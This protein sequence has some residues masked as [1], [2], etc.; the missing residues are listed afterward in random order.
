MKKLIAVVAMALIFAAGPA[1]AGLVSSATLIDRDE[2]VVGDISAIDMVNAG[3]AA[4]AGVTSSSYAA[5]LGAGNPDVV[6]NDGLHGYRSGAAAL[7]ASSNPVWTLTYSLNGGH[8]ID[9]IVTHSAAEDNRGD[10]DFEV[11]LETVGDPGNFVSLGQFTHK[12]WGAPF[13]GDTTGHWKVTVEDDGGAAIGTNVSAIRF[14]F[15]NGVVAP[16]FFSEIDVFEAGGNGGE[17][18]EPAGL[19]VIG[20]ALLAVR[21]RRS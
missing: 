21:K 20:L 17:V 14:A 18:P 1:M 9:S 6:L 13:D 3:S 11:L 10:Q 19:G 4:L 5:I 12:G 8:D 15:S 7:G 16:T 2:S